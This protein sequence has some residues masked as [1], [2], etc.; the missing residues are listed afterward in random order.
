MTTGNGAAGNIACIGGSSTSTI[1][2]GVG[3]L[4]PTFTIC[5]VSRYLGSGG[6]NLIA[7]GFN[8][9]H[10]YIGASKFRYYYGYMNPTVGGN[11]N[12]WLIVQG[13]QIREI[14]YTMELAWEMQ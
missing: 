10:T 3:S 6:S 2:F 11:I 8:S 12:N 14:C 9:T 7:K 13:Y 1:D 4:P 5:S